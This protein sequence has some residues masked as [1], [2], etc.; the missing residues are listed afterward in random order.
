MPLCRSKWKKRLNFGF[1][2]MTIKPLQ[3]LNANAREIMMKRKTAETKIYR[4][5]HTTYFEKL[6]PQLM[7]PLNLVQKGDFINIDFSEFQGRQVLMFAKQTRQG[8]AIPLYFEC[9][10]YPIE[11]GS[12]NIFIQKAI[13]N[14]LCTLRVQVHLIFDR[15]FAIPHLVKF[16]MERNVPFT[17]RIKKIK[18][19]EYHELKKAVSNLHRRDT[20][21]KVYGYELRILRSEK[22]D[23]EP[24]YLVTNDFE[25]SKETIIERYYYRFE[26]E[27]YFK[28]NKH[29]F[30]LG[31]LQH[32]T[33]QA[34]RILLWF[35]M[36]AAWIC[37]A[38][39][40]IRR[41]WQ[42]SLEKS[43][44]HHRCSFLRFW[45]EQLSRDRYLLSLS[46]LSS[47]V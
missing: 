33:D 40:S 39:Q 32:L 21:V 6:F 27:E 11:E 44:P 10:R 41:A 9:V 28:D 22:S 34:F 38:A 18:H 45:L 17:I 2:V 19:V 43:H 14:L 42:K 20:R 12:Q 26:I 36:M 35:V 7:A 1:E 16:L 25:S 31:H 23:L 37:W 29:L 13:S 46:A 24:W 5:V 30:R 15:G 47:K 8:R 4:V 3:S